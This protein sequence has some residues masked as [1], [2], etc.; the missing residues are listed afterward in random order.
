MLDYKINQSYKITEKDYYHYAILE[1]IESKYLHFN[2]VDTYNNN[3]I[4]MGEYDGLIIE[5]KDIGIKYIIEKLYNDEN[6]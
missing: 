1:I 2:P 6:V 3:G 4:F 5:K